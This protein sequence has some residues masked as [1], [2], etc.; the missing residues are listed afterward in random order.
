MNT[1]ELTAKL[2]LTWEECYAICRPEELFSQYWETDNIWKS[3]TK[4]RVS[5]R[6]INYKYPRYKHNVYGE[7]EVGVL[8]FYEWLNYLNSISNIN[9][10]LPP[11]MIGQM[12]KILYSKYYYFYFSDL[13]LLL[14]GILEGKYG[15]FFGSVDSQLIMTAFK[16]Y[17][18]ERRKLLKELEE[19][20]KKY[21]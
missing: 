20:K 6:D 1:N 17:D 9:K 18:T 10:P 16:V 19:E 11:Q 21:Q 3:I 15:H 8:Y 13:K 12:A 2:P 5:L 7:C 4:P 14:E